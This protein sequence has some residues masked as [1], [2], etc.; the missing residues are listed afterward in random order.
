MR[1]AIPP[2]LKT[3]Y[4]A[5][6]A[7]AALSRVVE[8]FRAPR[9]G[10]SVGGGPSRAHS[11]L[12]NLN[13]ELLPNVDIVGNAYDLPFRSGSVPFVFC[14]AVLEHL[15]F[16]DRAV[17]EMWR[18]LPAGG[19][20]FAATP[21][22]QPFHGFPGH[23]QNFTLEGHRRLFVRAGFEIVTAG[24]CVGPGV[25]VTELVA[26]YVREYVPTFV[27]SRLAELLVRTLTYPVRAFDR[28]LVRHRDA[29]VV[30]STTYVHARKP[31]PA[32]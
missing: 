1:F 6:E 2:G 12:R 30:S 17:R 8:A 11:S 32:A 13:I 22:L 15:E 20:L 5:P 14:E 21:F 26:T 3:A 7:D 28:V 27:L 18:V 19:E 9:P 10:I 23:F 29:H 16:P 4:R 25:A 31:S 24:V